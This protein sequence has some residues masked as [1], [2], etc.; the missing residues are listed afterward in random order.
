MNALTLAM[1]QL[2][3]FK[4]R[5]DEVFIVLVGMGLLS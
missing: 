2:P 3:Q 4:E 5:Q 1:M